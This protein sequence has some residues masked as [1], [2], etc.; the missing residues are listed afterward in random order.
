[1]IQLKPNYIHQLATS[2]KSIRK[3]KNEPIDIEDIIYAINTAIQ[4]PSGANTQPWRF[5]IITD[6][7]VKNEIRSICEEWERKFHESQSLPKWFREWLQKRN[8]SWE[9]PFLEEAPVL[10]VVLADRKA[11]YGRES[12]WLAI[13][14]ILLALE[15]RGLASLTYTPANPHAVTRYLGVPVNYTLEAIIPVGRSREDKVKEPRLGLKDTVYVNRW[16]NKLR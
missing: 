1:M 13:G 12:T 2:R 10:I 5:I 7:E 8:I 4:A 15:E 3:F 9:K 14:Y 6:K 11:P 16:G